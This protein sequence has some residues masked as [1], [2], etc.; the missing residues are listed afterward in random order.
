MN[1]RHLACLILTLGALHAPSAAA[2][3]W[4]NGRVQADQNLDG[5]ADRG[6]SGIAGVKLSNGRDVVLTGDDGRYRIALRDGDTLWLVKPPGWRAPQRADGLPST[7]QHEQ[8]RGSDGLR[9]GGRQR[10]RADGRFLL[11]PAPPP[12]WPLRIRVF[13][14]PQPRS[15]EQVGFFRD[16]IVV[17]VVGDPAD[18]GVSLGDIVDDELSLYPLIKSVMARLDTPWL[19]VPGNHDL[20]FDA[21]DDRRSLET[22]R[23]HFGADSFA[24]E[25]QGLS[26]IGLDDVL[27]D[28]ASRTYRGGLRE[29]QFAFL[30][31][32]LSTLP[33]SQR[34]I[35][36]VH[37]PLF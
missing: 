16:D 10:A 23:Q 35:L 11:Q 8:R 2:E 37:I 30:A 1:L 17:P 19:H 31:A 3:R 15:A 21:G 7:W 18:L 34:V 5:R 12:R 29:E 24:W 27:Y 6:A 22:F 26:L 9:Y 14:D 33:D 36:A 4:I 28:P 25:E 20:D 32:Y 13:G